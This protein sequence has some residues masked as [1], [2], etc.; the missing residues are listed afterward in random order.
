VL[1]QTVLKSL[2]TLSNHRSLSPVKGRHSSKKK[3]KKSGHKN[4][5]KS[6]GKKSGSRSKSKSQ[7]NLQN[8]AAPKQYRKKV[9]DGQKAAEPAAKKSPVHQK[10]D[11]KPRSAGPKKGAKKPVISQ[12][13]PPPPVVSSMPPPPV[14]MSSMPPPPV[15]VEPLL[16]V[17]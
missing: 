7:I 12:P 2:R 5:S 11:D 10:K 4:K 14:A 16:V 1:N 13:M 8:H 9:P 15:V 17:P 3:A 6:V